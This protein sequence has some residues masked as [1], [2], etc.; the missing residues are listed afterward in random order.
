MAKKAFSFLD[1]AGFR[2][3]HIEPSHLRYESPNSVVSIYWDARSGELEALVGLRSSAGQQQD[4]Y[5]LTDVVGMQGT[6]TQPAQVADESRLQPFV[7]QLADDLRHCAQPALAGDRMFFQ[8]LEAFRHANGEALT[9]DLQLRQVRSA[10]EV[11]WRN[12]DF[13]KVTELYSS[14]ERDLSEVEKSK[15]EYARRQRAD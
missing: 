3:A 9:R 7:D 4:T 12:Q 8:R 2:L 5:S 10:A 1:G 13:A 6:R 11:A 15:L 14:V